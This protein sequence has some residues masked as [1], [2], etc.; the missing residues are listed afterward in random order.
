[1][2]PKENGA[3]PHEPNQRSASA[4]EPYFERALSAAEAP[5]SDGT[6]KLN[7]WGTY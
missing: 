1:M 6:R 7:E 4:Y 2:R 3:D 5:S